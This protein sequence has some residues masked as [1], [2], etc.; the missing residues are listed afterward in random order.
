VAGASGRLICFPQDIPDQE[1][2]R[3]R[4]RMQ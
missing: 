2:E 3:Y 1:I 4:E